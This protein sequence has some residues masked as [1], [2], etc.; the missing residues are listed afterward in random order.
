[1]GQR[2]EPSVL[3]PRRAEQVRRRL[4][5]SVVTL[6][7]MVADGCF[8]EHADTIGL[9]VE[10]DLVDPLGRPRLVNQPVLARLGRSDLQQELGQFN[11]ELNVAPR[12]LTGPVLREL[13]RE[14][15]D[16][17]TRSGA[18]IADLG[19]RLVAIG[20]LPTLGANE[21]TYDSLSANPR[22]A[23]LSHRMRSARHGPFTVQIEGRES[24]AFATDSVAPEA[25]A[26]SLQL[27]LRVTADRFAAFY[28]AAQAIAAVQVAVAANA[29]FLLGRNL[30]QETRIALC[31]Q[32]LDTRRTAEI[33]RGAPPR[34]WLGDR[35][36][37]GAVDLFGETVRDF[38]P[39]L[40][41]ITA[42]DPEQTLTS[43]AAPEL[44]EL[45]LHNGTVWRWNRPVYDVQDGRPHLRIE[46]RLLP[47]GP[48]AADMIANAA[49]Y[50]G[51]VRAL[52][53]TEPPIWAGT[54]FDATERDLHAA[55]K[56]GLDADIWWAGGHRPVRDVILEEI[57]PL[58]A[59]GLTRWRVDP[60]DRDRYLGIIEARV[61]SGRT[62]ATW[63]TRTVRH[64]EAD[65]GFARPAA[66][67]EMT[68][69]YAE[70]ARD[71]APVHEW[72]IP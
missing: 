9:E 16:M 38:P 66:L 58:A 43:G 36:V 63:Q 27:H 10:L 3:A 69:R 72:P 46:N 40:P 57:L 1:M 67:R 71:G 51:L 33:A 5:R 62:G 7:R 65:R 49:L 41:L 24:L 4:E 64:L 34:V 44:R 61:R 42:E 8:R 14:L 20:T 6:G 29:P 32:M 25:A 21:L 60:A 54:P 47:A 23:V 70:H 56:N 59:D 12:P 37:T 26:T 39:L 11:I 53:D 18:Q 19:A 52:A 35:W 17:L 31:E 68:R 45:R 28:N 13:E 55:A 22:Y 2:V 50:Y 15:T 30:W 48:T